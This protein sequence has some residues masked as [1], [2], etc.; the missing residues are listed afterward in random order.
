MNK[1]L[2]LLSASILLISIVF[3]STEVLMINFTLGVNDS[4]ELNSIRLEEG[5]ETI[6]YG[7][8]YS[9]VLIVLVFKIP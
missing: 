7:T 9:L 1:K 8:E 6:A 3:A 5:S 2:I 4:V